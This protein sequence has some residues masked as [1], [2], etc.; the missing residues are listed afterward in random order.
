MEIRLIPEERVEWMPLGRHVQHDPRNRSFPYVPR[1]TGELRR[2]THTLS[3]GVLDQGNVGSC[4]GNAVATARNTTPL[5][6]KRERLLREPDA[7]EAYTLATTLDPFP[8]QMPQDDTG[9][10]GLAACQAARQLGWIT[11]YRWAFG[12]AD[13]LAALQDRAVITGV[14]WYEGF[15]TPGRNHLVKLEGQ[16]RGGHEFCVYGYE[17]QPAGHPAGDAIVLCAN[18]W[19]K[20]WGWYGRFAM[21]VATWADL[22]AAQGDVTIPLR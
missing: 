20:L 21:H 17:P 6:R 12:L 9:S 11:E 13:A 18:S 15:D 7:L 16:V 10:S 2:V 22:L 14:D 19:S 8:G 3:G 1:R 5:H 4:T